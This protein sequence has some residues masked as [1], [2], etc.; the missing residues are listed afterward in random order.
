MA[1]HGYLGDDYGSGFD[2]DYDRDRN[3]RRERGWGG[4]DQRW[5]DN[6]RGGRFMFE[7]RERSGGW[8]GEDRSRTERGRGDEDRGFFSRMGDQARSWFDDDDDRATGRGSRWDRGDSNEWFG[9]RDRGLQR[10]GSQRGMSQYGREH[11]FGGFQGDYSGRGQQGGF[12]GRGDWQ[13]GRE[14]R[15]RSFSSHPD[16]HYLSWREKQLEALDRDYEEY[17]REREQQFHQD[18]GSWRQQRQGQSGG[19]SGQMKSATSGSGGNDE[20]LL[21]RGSTTGRATG[22]TD[23]VN[24]PTSTANPDSAATL[25]EGG[26]RSGR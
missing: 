16:H 4:G 7:D 21:E 20:L 24:E 18:F 15:R 12:G 6:D 1:Q 22:R 13:S 9:G 14:G 3:D 23:A 26:G 19:P 17:C 25:G 8:G 5:R 11:G 2:P 10:G